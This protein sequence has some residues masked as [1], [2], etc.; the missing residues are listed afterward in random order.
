M[1]AKELRE[2][3]PQLGGDPCVDGLG[4]DKGRSRKTREVLAGPV[5]YV[6]FGTPCTTFSAALRGAARLR[7]VADPVGPESVPKIAAANALLRN[8]L[9]IIRLLAKTGG[10]WSIE[11]PRS[12]LLWRFPGVS[13]LG[14]FAVDFDA[15]AYKAMSPGEGVHQEADQAAH[16][17]PCTAFLGTTV[18]GHALAHAAEWYGAV[19]REVGQSHQAGS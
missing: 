4:S 2:L 10:F 6:H 1:S 7:S 3:L 17:P 14:G 19:P 8:M 5:R 9:Q 16:E 12:S 11:N 18:P 13:E 15:C